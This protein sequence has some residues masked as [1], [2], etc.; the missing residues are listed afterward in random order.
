[1]GR[2]V[3]RHCGRAFIVPEGVSRARC[4]HCHTTAQVGRS[5]Q[6]PAGR[7]AGAGW[8]GGQPRQATSPPQPAGPMHP[9]AGTYSPPLP[10]YPAESRWSPAIVVVPLVLLFMAAAAVVGY[11]VLGRGLGLAEVPLEVR[12]NAPGARWFLDGVDQGLVLDGTRRLVR[13]GLR[14]IRFEL[15]AAQAEEAVEIGPWQRE[16]L[17]EHTFSDQDIVAYVRAGTCGIVIPNLNE[18]PM[19]T[20]FL[21][22]L[23]PASGGVRDLAM[24]GARDADGRDLVIT[25][26]HVADAAMDTSHLVC[27]FRTRDGLVRCPVRYVY[28]IDRQADV[29]VLVLA[30]RAPEECQP[31]LLA[32]ELPRAGTEVGLVGNPRDVAQFSVIFGRVSA[33]DN[34]GKVQVNAAVEPG[35]SGGPVFEVARGVVVGITS[36]KFLRVAQQGLAAPASTVAGPLREWQ[37]DSA[38]ALRTAQATTERFREHSTRRVAGNAAWLGYGAIQGYAAI[39]AVVVEQCKSVGWQAAPQVARTVI[40]ALVRGDN[41]EGGGLEDVIFFVPLALDYARTRSGLPKSVEDALQKLRALHDQA[42]RTAANPGS[43]PSPEAYLRA[44]EAILGEAKRA[45]QV[46][47]AYAQLP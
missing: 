24:V 46:V 32:T 41:D 33:S 15:G 9:G 2:I 20:G 42:L 5:G 14:K 38:A 17:I 36:A 19:G 47:L 6:E 18:R 39:A 37:Q 28:Y 30:R 7:H 13:P 35:C 26:A 22:L 21:A 29:A 23:P 11:L 45:H 40:A 27:V 34:D 1:M 25:A 3:C 16:A 12:C 4:P 8:R 44:M 31:L 10:S 43:Y